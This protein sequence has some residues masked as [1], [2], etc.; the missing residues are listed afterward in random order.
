MVRPKT[1][2]FGKNLS[3]ASTVTSKTYFSDNAFLTLQKYAMQREGIGPRQAKKA[4]EILRGKKPISERRG[5]SKDFQGFMRE[6]RF[7][8]YLAEIKDLKGFLPI[9]TYFHL[10]E[11]KYQGDPDSTFKPI[12]LDM[13]ETNIF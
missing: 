3:N 4:K 11:E 9:R 5:Q 13:Q 1:V 8:T 6:Y 7:R 2:R 12:R 10:T